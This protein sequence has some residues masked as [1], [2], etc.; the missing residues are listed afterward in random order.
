MEDNRKK[1]LEKIIKC[2]FTNKQTMIDKRKNQVII[3]GS[4]RADKCSF[5]ET[6]K[7]YY[8]NLFKHT[9]LK[10]ETIFV[11]KKLNNYKDFDRRTAVDNAITYLE[12]IGIAITCSLYCESEKKLLARFIYQIFE[13]ILLVMFSFGKDFN[14]KEYNKKLEKV[15]KRYHRK[16]VSNGI[17]SSIYSNAKWSDVELYKEND[18]CN[19]CLLIDIGSDWKRM[20]CIP[21]VKTGVNI[22]INSDANTVSNINVGISYERT[23]LNIL[24]NKPIIESASEVCH[25]DFFHLDNEYYVP[26]RFC[27][28]TNVNSSQMEI[29]TKEAPKK[30]LQEIY[31]IS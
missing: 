14:E 21:H 30:E 12:S 13:E 1:D 28:C 25:L 18:N 16:I 20:F 4:K 26:S 22:F 7:E 2:V 9:F 6:D 27:Y 23:K 29:Y 10:E 8:I 11:D 19:E 31:D 5:L 3:G 15:K 24:N 17:I